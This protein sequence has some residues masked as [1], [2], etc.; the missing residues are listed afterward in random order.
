MFEPVLMIRKQHFLIMHPDILQRI[1][2]FQ[3]ER[4]RKNCLRMS[5]LRP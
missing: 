4:E 3:N 2:E 5:A 1:G